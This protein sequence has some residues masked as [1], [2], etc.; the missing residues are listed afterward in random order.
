MAEELGGRR[1]GKTV[2]E[3]EKGVLR[4]RVRGD[5]GGRER[6]R[7]REGVRRGSLREREVCS[8]GSTGEEGGGRGEGGGGMARSCG[9]LEC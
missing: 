5:V 4:N 8:G 7:K 6:G 2:R 3:G 9:T 1:W